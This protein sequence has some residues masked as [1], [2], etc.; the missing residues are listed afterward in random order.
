M[1]AAGVSENNRQLPGD[2]AA[3]TELVRRARATTFNLIARKGETHTLSTD[4][5]VPYE[6]VSPAQVGQFERD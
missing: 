2:R 1:V 5:A 6:D 4:D 3:A